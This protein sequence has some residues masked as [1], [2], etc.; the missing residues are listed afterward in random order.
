MPSLHQDTFAPYLFHQGTNYYA[1]RYLGSHVGDDGSTVFRVWAPHAD[2]VS[3]VGDFCNWDVGIPMQRIT[4]QGIWEVF[5][6]AA[7]YAGQP[8][9]YRIRTKDRVF[10]KAD[11]YA[12]ASE[13]PPATASLIPDRTPYVWHDDGWR[14]YRAK[15]MQPNCFYEQ[16]INIYELH[17]L[18]FKRHE[19]DTYLTW[20][21]LAEELAPYVKRMGY[22]HVELM[23]VMEHPYDGSW[24]YQVCSYFAPTAR[25]GTPNDFRAFVDMMHEAGIG[26]IL[27]WVP[28]HFPKDAHGLYEFDG[29]PLY[30][31]QGADRMEHSTWGTRCFDVG[32][33]EVQSFLISGAS[34]WIEE[35]HADGLRVDAVASMLYLD[36]DREP[37]TWFPNRYGNNRNLEAIAFFKKLNAHLH[38]AYPD[39]L[40]IAEESGDFGGVTA[41]V[42][43][44]GLGFSMKWNMGW[45]NDT[46][47]YMSQ[48]PIYRKYHHNKLN[49]SLTYSFEESYVLPIS[50]D[51]V[52]HGKKSL[53]DRMPGSYEQKFANQRVFY[54]WQMTHPGKKLS[55][56]SNEIGQFRE[57]DY[58]GSVEWFMTDYPM[59]AAMQRYYAALN[60][61]YL[62]HPA[63]W[64]QDHSWDG[65]SWINP[66]DAECSVLSFL[67]I[68]RSPAESLLIVL[69]FTPVHRENYRL[70]LQTDGAWLVLFS[71]D[72][73]HFGG[74]GLCPPGTVVTPCRDGDSYRLDLSLPPLSAIILRPIL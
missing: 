70:S 68:S 67:R 15:V 46:L 56:M 42:L 33:P 19:D 69:N 57:W 62:K 40:T 24:G 54:A 49:F 9:K 53:L 2:A 18:S 58:A 31:Y 72:D 26:V 38:G 65:F 41:D 6:T 63:L 44:G 55:F 27:D 12:T 51:E 48:D 50:H 64:Q 23:P 61:F 59:H 8:Y 30:E 74:A 7:L 28:A 43:N 47:S 20:R 1:Y 37:G 25:L 11:P 35:F 17:A 3:L 29:Q 10:L 22:T 34:F 14:A 71:S 45:M 13:C 36:Y 32:R 4:E 60:E 39:V 16:P 73:M 5:V 66:D 52:V 21:E